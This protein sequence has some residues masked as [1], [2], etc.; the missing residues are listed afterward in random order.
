LPDPGTL[1]LLVQMGSSSAVVWESCCK[2]LEILVANSKSDIIRPTSDQ[3]EFE[4][5]QAVRIAVRLFHNHPCMPDL[6]MQKLLFEIKVGR[7]QLAFGL[8]CA[9]GWG[10]RGGRAPRQLRQTW[11]FSRDKG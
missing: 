3:Q 11:H 6:E 1:L 2:H 10:E 4:A 9:Y 7:E 8:L 5:M